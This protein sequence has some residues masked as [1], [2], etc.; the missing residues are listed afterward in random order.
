MFNN[1]TKQ[2]VAKENK[3]EMVFSFKASEALNGNLKA[4]VEVLRL[5]GVKVT[6]SK[7][8]RNYVADGLAK[9]HNCEV[10]EVKD[11]ET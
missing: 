1:K 10:A 2:T 5:S 4:R 9:D 7:L 11:N 3:K 8:M 6:K